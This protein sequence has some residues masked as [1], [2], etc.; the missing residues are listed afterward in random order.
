MGVGVV[1]GGRLLVVVTDR[2]VLVEDVDEVVDVVV[3]V[4]VVQFWVQTPMQ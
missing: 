4:V 1:T 3:V 2:V